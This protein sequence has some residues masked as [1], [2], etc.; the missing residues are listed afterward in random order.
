[1]PRYINNTSGVVNPVGR[2][3]V[4]AGEEFSMG[5]YL[6][7]HKTLTV[8]EHAAEGACGKKLYSAAI[9]GAAIEYLNLYDEIEVV[10]A[11]DAIIY[12]QPN[13][14]STNLWAVPAGGV[15]VISNRDPRTWYKMTIT[16]SGSGVVHVMG[17]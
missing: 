8:L 16:G 14:D 4:A 17:N 15:R 7:D 12:L 13:E 2:K 10:N 6:R 1:M 11:T 9:G 5:E 3:Q